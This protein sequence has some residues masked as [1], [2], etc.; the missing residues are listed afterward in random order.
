M[1]PRAEKAFR[2]SVELD[3]TAYFVHIELGNLYLKH[4]SREECLASYSAALKYAPGEPVIRSALQNQ[5]QRVSRE[6][7]AGIRPLRSPGLE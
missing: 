5:I 1:M 3:P 4:G 7:L 2:R 6:P